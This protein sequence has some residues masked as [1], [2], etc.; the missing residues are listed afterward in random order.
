MKTFK[1]LCEALYTTR[2]YYSSSLQQNVLCGNK[3]LEDYLD[4]SI[5]FIESKTQHQ[6]DE[7]AYDLP[8]NELPTLN[9]RKEFLDSKKNL[10]L[11]LKTIH[12]L[13]IYQQAKQAYIHNKK[14][15]IEDL[16]PQIFNLELTRVF[17]SQLFHG[18]SLTKCEEFSNPEEFVPAN[19][20]AGK[21][22]RIFNEGLV[23]S[24]GVHTVAHN[25]DF[26]PIYAS[27]NP[28]FTHGIAG[29]IIDSNQPLLHSYSQNPE[30]VS[31][32]ASRV[33]PQSFFIKS[34]EFIEQ[35]NFSFDG[36]RTQGEY[37]SSPQKD[38][39]KRY[40]EEVEKSFQ[41]SALPYY[42]ITDDPSQRVKLII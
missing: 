20:Y 42:V 5:A 37:L 32:F 9:S 2:E 21:I 18:V 36:S 29:V 10:F 25:H 14:E 11:A 16:L 12:Q 39:L 1:K 31:I 30:E 27:Q 8:E 22:K 40:I 33:F 26:K 24:K 4:S 3:T 35:Q 41:K 19:N 13:D 6:I 7:L 38:M 23:G 28:V 15:K 17:S 34:Y